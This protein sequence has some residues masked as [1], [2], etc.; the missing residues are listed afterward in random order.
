MVVY[1]LGLCRLLIVDTGRVDTMTALLNREETS[2]KLS[3]LITCVKLRLF[4]H[5]LS[6]AF[7]GAHRTVKYLQNANRWLGF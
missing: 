7:L 6:D 4:Q 2:A 5:I 3:T 1:T